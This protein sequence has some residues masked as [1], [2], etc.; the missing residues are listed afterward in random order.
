MHPPL[1]PHPPPTLSTRKVLYA[2]TYCPSV[3]CVRAWARVW[4]GYRGEEEQGHVPMAKW[5]HGTASFNQIAPLIGDTGDRRRR[6]VRGTCHSF[7]QS[8]VGPE[9]EK[10]RTRSA[11]FLLSY[12]HLQRYRIPARLSYYDALSACLQM[13][14]TFHRFQ[15]RKRSITIFSKTVGIKEAKGRFICSWMTSWHRL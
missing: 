6:A 9:E 3:V 7:F 10:K 5:D 4:S 12:Q 13:P 1:A 8:H 15:G 2:P 14:V 11:F